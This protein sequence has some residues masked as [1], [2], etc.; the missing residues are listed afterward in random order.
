MNP[1][2]LQLLLLQTLAT[3]AQLPAQ[4]GIPGACAH[5]DASDIPLLESEPL[6]A[7]K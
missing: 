1:N 5:G 2:P 6:A 4:F 3:V 7:M